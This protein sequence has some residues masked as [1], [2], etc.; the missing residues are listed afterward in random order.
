MVHS[1]GDAGAATTGLLRQIPAVN[2]LLGRTALRDL[3]AHA[4][5]RLVVESTRRVLRRLRDRI[6]EG[7]L[8]SVSLEALE[9]E[10][11]I[12]TEAAARFS[13]RAVINA[14]GVVLHTNLGRAPLAREAVEHLAEVSTCYSNLEYDLDRGARGKRDAHRTGSFASF[15]VR[16]KRCW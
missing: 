7:S 1:E 16:K 4:G 3:Q 13:L 15:S 14:S 10:I 8:S 5:R 9:Q 11:V 2:E 6:V 12:E